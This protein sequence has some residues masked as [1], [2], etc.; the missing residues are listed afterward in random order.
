MAV[1][2][3]KAGDKRLSKS[4]RTHNRRVKQA[5]LR[6]F[7]RPASFAMIT[8]RASCYQVFPGMLAPQTS[9]H[10]MVHSQV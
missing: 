2:K 4:K 1:T 7:K 3:R 5:H 10:D 6:L 9:W 8:V